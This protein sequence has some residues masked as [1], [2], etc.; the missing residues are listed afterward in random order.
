MAKKK[1][2]NK[3]S[4]PEA[5]DGLESASEYDSLPDIPEE[6]VSSPLKVKP[7]ASFALRELVALNKKDETMF[8]VSN[9]VLC[10]ALNNANLSMAD[11]VTKS[12][13]FDAIRNFEK[14]AA[15]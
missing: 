3:M 5:T 10:G 13:V 15:F 12:Q 6:V 8:N 1:K 4:D 7:E 11:M 9:H 2:D 14:V